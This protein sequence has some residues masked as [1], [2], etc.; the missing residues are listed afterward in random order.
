MEE[1][2]VMDEIS[3]DSMLSSFERLREKL[4]GGPSSILARR[5]SEI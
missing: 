3:V 2:V 5:I 4:P 1:L